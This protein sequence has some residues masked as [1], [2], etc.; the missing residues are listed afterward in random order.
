LSNGSLIIS[1]YTESDQSAAFGCILP[2][3]PI[4]LAALIGVAL[5]SLIYVIA[6]MIISCIC[7]RFAREDE[8]RNSIPGRELE[9]ILMLENEFP[10]PKVDLSII[11]LSEGERHH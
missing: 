8:A 7:N 6:S 5:G 1:N 11:Y 10:M 3:L 2:P 9:S 4:L